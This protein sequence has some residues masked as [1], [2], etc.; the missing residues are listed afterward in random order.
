MGGMER[1]IKVG[2]P[3]LFIAASVWLFVESGFF[4][5][6]DND[7]LLDALTATIERQE[8]SIE[9]GALPSFQSLERLRKKRTAL[10][11]LR[12]EFV[13]V[14]QQASSD[15]DLDSV[16]KEWG[17]EPE[18]PP[19]IAIK[20]LEKQILRQIGPSKRKEKTEAVRIF[21]C[22]TARKAGDADLFT[23]LTL[24]ALRDQTA[25]RAAP[26]GTLLAFKIEFSFVA[27]VSET[28]R[29]I[30]RWILDAP[31]GVFIKPENMAFQRVDPNLWGSSL[32][33]YSGPPVRV[34]LDIS[35]LINIDNP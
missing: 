10:L 23:I 9:L 28:V 11:G 6:P 32:K 33:Y 26:L 21:L 3:I 31:A 1:V 35:V 4:H 25:R 27:G 5:I 18:D 16:L 34:D 12:Q 14:A 2:S 29:F 17:Y 7:A 24:T 20:E 15:E 30:E 22:D 19:T 13:A 8:E